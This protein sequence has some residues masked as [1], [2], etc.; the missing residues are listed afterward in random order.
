M[1]FTF[2]TDSYQGQ[3]ILNYFVPG[4]NHFIYLRNQ[5]RN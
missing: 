1:T 4:R 3:N 2:I 5:L